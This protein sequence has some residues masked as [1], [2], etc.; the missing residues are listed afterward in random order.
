M[1]S[2]HRETAPAYTHSRWKRRRCYRHTQFSLTPITAPSDLEAFRTGSRI[3]CGIRYR[4]AVNPQIECESR[5]RRLQV[6]EAAQPNS[7]LISVLPMNP[8]DEI[9]ST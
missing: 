8:V 3:T 5:N 1:N 2:P 9:G 7:S 6:S 4:A